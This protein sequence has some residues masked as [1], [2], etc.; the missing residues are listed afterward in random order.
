MFIF[1]QKNLRN[2]PGPPTILIMLIHDKW[3]APPNR[4]EERRRPGEWIQERCPRG[5]HMV[6]NSRSLLSSTV[7]CFDHFHCTFLLKKSKRT[8][9]WLSVSRTGGREEKGWG[10]TGLEVKAARRNAAPVTERFSF[11]CCYWC[12][13]PSPSLSFPS[14]L[15]LAVTHTVIPEYPM[16]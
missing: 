3:R 16:V 13:F 2:G 9:C 14:S 11:T 10:N 6:N 4:K 8:A 12:I 5:K 1:W 15:V 7:S